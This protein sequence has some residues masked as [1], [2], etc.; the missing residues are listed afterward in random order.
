[1][2]QGID[3]QENQDKIAIVV[4]GYSRMD[5][6]VRLLNSLIS[7]HYTVDDIPLVISV[8]AS[9]NKQL[10]DYVNQFQWNHGDKYVNIERNLLGLKKHIFQ[11]A[12]LSK[13]FKAVVILEDDIVVSP[14]FYDYCISSLE[15]YGND[16]RIAGISLYQ[17]ETN[18]YVGFPFQSVENGSDSYA[19]QAVSS[20]GEMWNERMWNSFDDWL[21]EWDQDFEP[22]D[23]MSCIKNWTRAWSRYMYAYIIL[24]DKYFI[25]PYVSLT[26]NFNDVGGEHGGGNSSIVQ[27]SLLQGSK[28]YYFLPFDDLIKYDVYCNNLNIPKW[29]GIDSSKIDVDLYGMRESYNKEY[30][31]TTIKLPYKVKQSFALN[32]RPIELNV[33][34]N[35]QGKGLYLYDTEMRPCMSPLKVYPIDMAEYYLR[36]FNFRLLL[37][38]VRISI[39]SKL[40]KRISSL[41]RW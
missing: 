8:D 1:M 28:K 41:K 6:I 4:V 12:S 36:G 9:G 22:I 33:K 27:V 32:M 11:C 14:Y 30:V 23:M 25:Y 15:I 3:K 39:I 13:Y 17:E 38:Y 29:L 20:W 26:T 40:K 18:G 21:S 16:E 7:A 35:I 37:K 34:Y 31:L 24:N 10:Y 5:G 19:V 2:I